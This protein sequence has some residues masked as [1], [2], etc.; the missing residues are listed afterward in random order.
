MFSVDYV[1]GYTPQQILCNNLT[2]SFHR[3]FVYLASTITSDRLSAVSFSRGCKSFCSGMPFWDDHSIYSFIN[4]CLQQQ[5][6]L[7]LLQMV[8]TQV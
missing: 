7:L 3:L 6:L 4:L 5:Q 2:S 1:D 8:I